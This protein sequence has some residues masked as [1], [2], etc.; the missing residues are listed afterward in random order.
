[1]G[2]RL[3]VEAANPLDDAGISAGSPPAA[4]ENRR[5]ATTS[6][7]PSSEFSIWYLGAGVL[8]TGLL[9]GALFFGKILCFKKCRR[10]ES[11]R[12]PIYA[13]EVT[14]TGDRVYS[15]TNWTN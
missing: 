15:S 13:D 14:H 10:R 12:L 6:F 11:M 4:G 3:Y 2:D 7:L 8:S 5:L 1:M 9:V